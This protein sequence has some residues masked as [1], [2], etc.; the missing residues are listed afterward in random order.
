[1]LAVRARLQIAEKEYDAALATIQVGYSLGCHVGQDPIFVSGLVGNALIHNMNEQLL[2][3][4]QQP[5]AP[6][7]YW[8]LTELPNPMVDL[9]R[10]ADVEYDMLYL[11][12]PELQD[13]R[14]ADRSP[15]YWDGMLRKYINEFEKLRVLVTPNAKPVPLPENAV[16]E[17]LAKLPKAKADLVAAGFSQ[18][19]LDAMTPARVILLHGVVSYEMLRDD[20]FKW[21][22]V[23]YWQA[24]EA[25][26][27]MELRLKEAEKEEILH[28]SL[29]LPAMGSIAIVGARHERDLA[30]LRCIE[31][32]RLYAFRHAGKLPASLD[33][34]K[35]TPLP[36]NAVT[37]KPFP[38]HLEGETAVLDVLGGVSDGSTRK[39]EQQY[40]ISVAK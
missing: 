34:I 23:P 25:F 1:M 30:A 14:T 21:G 24:R 39:V 13:L 6:N 3:F 35:E 19:E 9:V 10:S 38:Y 7:L 5:G 12:Y 15:Q 2:T 22:R 20:W 40:R 17:A 36:I 31:A 26:E 11:Q 32:L 33:D 37:G 29:I 8:S 16:A 18:A 28:T 27:T 4:L